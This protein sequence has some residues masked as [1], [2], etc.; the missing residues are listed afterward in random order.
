[1]V[2]LSYANFFMASAGAAAALVGLL[3]IAISIAPE[4]TISSNASARRQ[5]AA[6]SAFTALLNAFFVSLVALVPNVNLTWV[7]LT[8]GGI[9]ILNSLVLVGSLFRSK[10]QWQVVMR[11]VFLILGS[12]TLYS[13][14]VYDGVLMLHA[15]D[16][17]ST[18]LIA[19]LLMI[20]CYGLGLARSW[21]IL[22]GR[23]NR[24]SELMLALYHAAEQKK[25]R[26]ATAKKEGEQQVGVQKD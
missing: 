13:Y 14:E 16:D 4:Q 19:T 3:F 24:L 7:M 20:G 11:G 5:T 6:S 26:E 8:I 25:A 10:E 21:E 1:M 22:G 12:I 15:P 23:N 17:S 2:P 18:V 9:G